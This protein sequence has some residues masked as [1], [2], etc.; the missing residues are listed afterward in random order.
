MDGGEEEKLE[1]MSGAQDQ[2][3]IITPL[4]VR[5]DRSVKVHS[6]CLEEKGMMRCRVCEAEPTVEM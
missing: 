6:L 4:P 1:R 3:T 5:S 2:P